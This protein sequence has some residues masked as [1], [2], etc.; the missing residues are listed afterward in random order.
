[1]VSCNDTNLRYFLFCTQIV[2]KVNN[3][4]CEIVRN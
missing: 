4:W 3:I 1:M 2:I